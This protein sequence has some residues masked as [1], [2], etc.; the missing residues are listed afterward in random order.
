MEGLRLALRSD[1][2]A[3]RQPDGRLWLQRQGS[4]IEL[5]PLRGEPA[6]LMDLFEGSGV[7]AKA[8]DRLTLDAAHLL[9][10]LD[11]R[12]WLA[13]HLEAGGRQVVS[14]EPV[15]WRR[16]V[17]RDEPTGE[18]IRLSRF[19]HL[20]TVDGRAI[21]ESPRARSSLLVHDAEA[22]AVLVALAAPLRLDSL[23]GARRSV[24]ELLLAAGLAVDLDGGDDPEHENREP[25]QWSFADLLVHSEHRT[26]DDRR[27]RGGTYPLADRFPPLPAAKLSREPDIMLPRPRGEPAGLPGPPLAAV[28]ERRRS[29]RDHDDDA[30]IT[31]EQL[32]E[33]LFRAARVRADGSGEDPYQTTDRPFPSGGAMGELELY[34][35]VRQCAG[36]PPGLHRYDGRTHGLIGVSEPSAATEGLMADARWAT[37]SERSPQ[38]LIV[39]AARVG[40]VTWKY[41]GIG[42]SL[43]LKHVG[44]LLQTMYLVATAMGLAPCAIGTGSS[45]RFALASGLDPLEEPSVGEFMLGSA[46]AA[47]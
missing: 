35:L 15:G 37:M 2:S 6:A 23:E 14:L 28:L 46:P 16:A 39:I 19:A 27:S 43:V 9:D 40:R 13:R 24:A 47:A 30:P 7:A 31:S 36:L 38:V 20:H 4:G 34:P 5:G 12:G 18:R 44:V 1:A 22:A 42:Y 25:A 32:G 29:I 33:F 26:A 3:D 8:A 41:E 45:E 11:Q 21:V 17:T 10:L